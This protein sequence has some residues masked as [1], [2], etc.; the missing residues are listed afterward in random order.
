MGRHVQQKLLTSFISSRVVYVVEKCSFQDF[1]FCFSSVNSGVRVEPIWYFRPPGR[2]GFAKKKSCI[3]SSVWFRTSRSGLPVSLQRVRCD[4]DYPG[5]IMAM[6]DQGRKIPGT[7][8]ARVVKIMGNSLW[9]NL[10]NALVR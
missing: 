9:V 2:I 3:R 6:A 5:Q 1:G 10:G 7:N 4:L 8:C